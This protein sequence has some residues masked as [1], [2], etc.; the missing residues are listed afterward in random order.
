MRCL[1][2]LPERQPF[3]VSRSSKDAYQFPHSAREGE[4]SSASR[5]R[6]MNKKA[7]DQIQP[8][9]QEP[10]SVP[11]PDRRRFLRTA[12]LSIAGGSAALAAGCEYKSQLFLLSSAPTE[13]TK[14]S[15]QWQEARVHSYRPLGHTGMQMSDISFGCASLDNVAVVKRALER[16]VTYFDTSPDYSRAGSERILGEG[17]KGYPRD[18]LFIVSKFCT[19]DG[20]LS[21]DTPSKDVIA[22]VEA[23]L[24]R[25]GIDYL[26]LAHIHA[27]DSLDRLMNPN[28]HEAFDRLKEQGK[29][30]FLGVSSHTPH[31]ETV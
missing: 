23:S 2:L 15:S 31:L 27:C 28:I 3:I 9:H 24:Q 18:K 7:P 8:P 4:K 1:I 22:A 25:L 17:I 20:H 29:L 16:G 13:A 26:D 30:R 5:R 11:N 10:P 21:N 19:P 14:K 12:A 6:S